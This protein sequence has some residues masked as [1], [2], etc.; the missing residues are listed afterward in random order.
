MKIKTHCSCGE[1]LYIGQGFKVPYCAVCDLKP[2]RPEIDLDKVFEGFRAWL[3]MAHDDLKQI[4][5]DIANENRNTG[6]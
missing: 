1:P 4:A 2:A 5:E 6:L 3:K